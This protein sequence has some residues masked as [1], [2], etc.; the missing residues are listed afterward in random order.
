MRNKLLYITLLWLGGSLGLSAQRI[1]TENGT[2][3]DSI[4]NVFTQGDSIDSKTIPT[5]IYTWRTTPYFGDKITVQPDT[6]PHLFPNTNY[7][8]G[9]T[10]QYSHIGNIGAPRLSRVF[11]TANTLHEPF[12]FT[13]PYDFFY[14]KP[15]EVVFTNT[16]SPF[17]NITYHSR[18]DRTTGDDHFKL[19]FATNVNKRLGFGVD[20]DYI[21]GRGYYDAQ[22]T[23]LLS[24]R[25][26]G[27]YV[28]S[29]YQSHFFIESDYTKMGENGG[30]EEDAYVIT[31]QNYSTN[32]S[33][34]DYP[35]K[36]SETWTRTGLFR[37]YVTQRYHIGIHRTYLSDGTLVKESK[38][39]LSQKFTQN[40]D[41]SLIAARP[42]QLSTSDTL[43]AIAPHN[44]SID[45][46]QDMVP[47]YIK[48]FIPVIS[49]IHTLQ[50]DKAYRKFTQNATPAAYYTNSE[51]YAA[52]AGSLDKTTH[53]NL[54]NV[55]GIEV[56][57]G[58]NKWMK[59][60]MKLFV[61]YD[62]RSFDLPTDATRYE[63]YHDNLLSLGAQ[64][65][66]HKGKYFN[67]DALGELATNGKTWGMFN[68]E[69]KAILNIPI[70]KD[71]LATHIVA[72]FANEAPSFYYR[73]YHSRY[74]WWDNTHLSN[75]VTS[76]LGGALYYK[77]TA[78]KLDIHS[79]QNYTYFTES[80]TATTNNK[81]GYTSAI[82]VSQA[83]KNI[84]VLTLTATQN[85]SWKA[86]HGELKATYQLSSEPS[87]LPLPTLTAYANLYL[88][89][90]IAK[91]LG[92]ELGVDGT[93]F[94]NY[95]A[96]V[97]TPIIGQFAV[98]E[99]DHRTQVG[100]YPLL[101][102]YANFHLSKCRFYIA[103][104][105]FN[106]SGDGGRSFFIPHYPLNPRGLQLGISWTFLN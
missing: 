21:Y 57:E 35:T 91:V 92:V 85:F 45:T 25:L 80:T 11:S 66:N 102:A 65:Y 18:G 84:Q 81:W 74:T 37:A 101:N 23:S 24:G 73:H 27:S 68:L 32:Y 87:V 67:F 19:L 43:L 93:Y 54:S 26:H 70:A 71:T 98:Q 76:H 78:L 40:T 94:T 105:H 42:A 36:L 20:V 12:I 50:L 86:L 7:T 82:K 97:Y 75:S 10:L 22:A 48:Q 49:F 60:G 17:T 3:I 30:L 59:A 79:L 8:A 62:L 77:K 69:G 31:P 99:G 4:E 55:F 51:Y 104:T 13:A 9:K 61:R 72:R 95:Y 5:G 34:R 15:H 44:D 63:R 58:F 96:P 16:K 28:G 103:Y 56:I 47:Q 41:T 89:F 100:N 106:A 39:A 29:R 53:F 88:R 2:S 33:T 46:A 38:S 6:I 14:K 52:T 1:I 64:L 90:R 83:D